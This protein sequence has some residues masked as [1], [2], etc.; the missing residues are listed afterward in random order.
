MFTVRRF[1]RYTRLDIN[2]D[3]G[4]SMP[5]DQKQAIM[6]CKV[7]EQSKRRFDAAM[8]A[9]GTTTSEQFRAAVLRYLEDLDSDVGNPQFIL[10]LKP[11]K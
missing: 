8:R 6:A 9:Q 1:N 7:D 5:T 11:K 3:V 2:P 10:E 4:H